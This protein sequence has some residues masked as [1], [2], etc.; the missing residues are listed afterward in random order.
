MELP[1]IDPYRGKDGS[2]RRASWW[3]ALACFVSDRVM[4]GLAL[5]GQ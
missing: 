3:E 4:E 5:A 2:S 1:W